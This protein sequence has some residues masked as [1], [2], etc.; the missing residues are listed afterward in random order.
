MEYIYFLTV[1]A[2][3]A[4]LVAGVTV[5]YINDCDREISHDNK[6][7]LL[8]ATINCIDGCDRELSLNDRTSMLEMHT[9]VSGLITTCADHTNAEIGSLRDEI[10]ELRD[11]IAAFRSEVT[12]LQRTISRERSGSSDH[13]SID[14]GVGSAQQPRHRRLGDICGPNVEI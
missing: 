10:H 1:G 2:A 6:T 5:G 7:D 8:E 11:T 3:V 13:P 9:E 12:F 14:F 4:A